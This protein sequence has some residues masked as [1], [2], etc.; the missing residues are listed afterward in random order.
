MRGAGD[1]HARAP[2]DRRSRREHR[3]GDRRS[4]L[5]S[6]W[7]WVLG[8]ITGSDRLAFGSV[9]TQMLHASPVP[10]LLVHRTPDPEHERLHVLVGADGSPSAATRVAHAGHHHGAE[11]RR[12]RG[13]DRRP[14]SRAGVLGAS[15]RVRP[16]QVHRG[17]PRGRE[18]RRQE[19]SGRDDR[20]STCDGVHRPRQSGHRLARERPPL[21]R[22]AR[23][24]RT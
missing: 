10:V 23:R 22:R 16:H 9:S 20:P 5:R 12:P 3:E 13:S 11:P 2:D 24:R 21:L 15:G 19:T 18:G 1:R 17:A 14:Y 4:G 8:T 7:S 6:R